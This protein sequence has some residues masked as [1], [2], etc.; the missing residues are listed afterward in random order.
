[1]ECLQDLVALR[2]QTV[3]CEEVLEPFRFMDPAGLNGLIEFLDRGHAVLPCQKEKLRLDLA[4][5]G[6]QI[7]PHGDFLQE[8]WRHVKLLSD[9]LGQHGS[10]S[11]SND[12]K[13]RI[14]CFR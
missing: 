6:F 11:F 10:D 8:V 13:R 14:D 2:F 12:P 3:E 9:V 4:S 5:P 1:M 7:C